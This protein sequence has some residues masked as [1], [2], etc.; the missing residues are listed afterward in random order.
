MS[1][2]AY[3]LFK[4]AADAQVMAED[5]QAKLDAAW[6][7][8]SEAVKAVGDLDKSDIVEMYVPFAEPPEQIKMVLECVMVILG[9][10]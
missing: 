7:E 6:P 4:T 1:P 2:E 3:V 8:Y 9:R 5:I 10:F